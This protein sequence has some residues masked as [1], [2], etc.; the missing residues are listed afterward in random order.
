MSIK[1]NFSSALMI[2][3]IAGLFTSCDKDEMEGI[4]NTETTETTSSIFMKSIT[5]EGDEDIEFC[6]EVNFPITIIYPHGTTQQANNEEQL[7]E[8]I[9]G[10]Y[11]QDEEPEEDLTVQFPI[12]VTLDDGTV[13]TLNSDDELEE[14]VDDECEYEE[15]EEEEYEEDEENCEDSFDEICFEVNFPITILYPDGTTQTANDED[16]LEE[17][18]EDFYENQEE[19]PEEDLEIQFPISATLE[20]G[21]VVTLNDEEELGE[22][23][24]E[25]C[26]DED[27]DD[28]EIEELCFEINFPISV[29][30][31]GIV[32]TVNN[33]EEFA[34]AI[35][36]YIETNPDADE[37]DIELQFPIDVTLDDGT[38][39]TLNNEDELDEL[40]EDECE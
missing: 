39:L 12:T 14:L 9:L 11:E 15:D 32:Q 30:I 37:D 13:T 16:E 6:F 36:T 4:E 33:F 35:I 34:M 17:L 40:I 2:L 31:E 26:G 10:Y 29:A 21:T 20:G 8:I 24:Y 1:K 22:L 25:E 19:N 27:Y 5:T 38:V 18:F 23:I 7:V 3:L 28:F